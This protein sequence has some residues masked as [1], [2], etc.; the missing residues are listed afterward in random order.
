MREKAV[1]AEQA[2]VDA[3]FDGPILISRVIAS[4]FAELTLF[5]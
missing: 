4:Y 2:N 1:T 3:N 5:L